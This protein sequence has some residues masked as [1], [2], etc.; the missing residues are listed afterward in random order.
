MILSSGHH[1]GFHKSLTCWQSLSGRQPPP[2]STKKLLE[3][4]EGEADVDTYDGGDDIDAD[5]DDDAVEDKT[6]QL[7]VLF[8]FC[9]QPHQLEIE[10]ARV[11]SPFPVVIII[12][13]ISIPIIIIII[14]IIIIV[15]II[16][17]VVIIIIFIFIIVTIVLRILP[18]E[19]LHLFRSQAQRSVSLLEKS[20]FK[21]SSAINWSE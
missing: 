13:S 19:Y 10:V 16:I 3:F 12:I 9:F 18:I 8:L 15:I 11:W 20:I 6:D 17:V 7:E 2:W 14:I 5:H 4:W 21:N 1:L